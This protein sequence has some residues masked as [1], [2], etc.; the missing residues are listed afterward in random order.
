MDTLTCLARTLYGEAR[1][2]YHR[3]DGGILAFYAVAHVILNRLKEP[4]KYGKTIQDVCLKSYQFSCWNPKDPN[5]AVIEKTTPQTHR[6]AAI[7]FQ[8]AQEVLEGKIPDPTLG[9]NHY[10]A[11]WLPRRPRWSE[12][13]DPLLIVGQ[14]IFFKL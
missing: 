9:A 8:A 12:G 14:H 4:T 10:F 1:G 6:L 3:Q 7:A 2:E 13:H 5:R 11:T